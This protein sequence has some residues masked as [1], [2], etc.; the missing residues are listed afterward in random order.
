MADGTPQSKDSHTN[1]PLIEGKGSPISGAVFRRTG[2]SGIIVDLDS[3]K[4]QP[5]FKTTVELVNAEVPGWKT[6]VV[7]S[8]KSMMPLNSES[9]RVIQESATTI[10]SY[11]LSTFSKNDKEIQKLHRCTDLICCNVN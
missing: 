7:E 9:E 4:S 8:A 2:R 5:W 6:Y 10:D 3:F 1:L 11:R